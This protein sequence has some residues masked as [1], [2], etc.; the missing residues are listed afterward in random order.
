MSEFRKRLMM[1]EGKDNT[2]HNLVQYIAAN[3]KSYIELP[4]IPNEKTRIV[5]Q[6]NR[7][8]GDAGYI[9]YASGYNSTFKVVRSGENTYFYFTQSTV[10][11]NYLPTGWGN[12]TIDIDLLNDNISINTTSKQISI[13]C[14][15]Y[16]SNLSNCT[17]LDILGGKDSS[18][19][20]NIKLFSV[21]IYDNNKLI[22][23]L[24]PFDDGDKNGLVNVLN[25][26][27]YTDVNGYL[28]TSPINI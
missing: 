10:S 15:D 17:R 1:Q 20:K 2:V 13:Y 26:K 12:Y 11:G 14:P 19:P 28:F 25:N 5:A 22:Y 16:L 21:Q 3:G 23:D 6:L 18:Y 4:F 7:P 24:R 9:F 8:I 27:I